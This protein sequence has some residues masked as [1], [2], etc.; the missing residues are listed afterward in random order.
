MM[1]E[2]ISAIEHT[3]VGLTHARPISCVLNSLQHLNFTS[4]SCDLE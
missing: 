3:S 1:Y 4:T 2:N